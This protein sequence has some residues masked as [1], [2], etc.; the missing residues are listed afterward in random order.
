ME[1]EYD[2]RKAVANFKKHGIDFREAVEVFE[3][4][5]LEE[6]D[7]RFTYDEDRYQ[8]LGW[9]H[10]RMLVLTVIYTPREGRIRL[11]SARRASRQE[12]RIYYA[13]YP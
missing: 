12:R 11:I 13:A 1:I 2:P 8:V 5:Y 6:F 4:P 7:D 3:H 10:S 9:S